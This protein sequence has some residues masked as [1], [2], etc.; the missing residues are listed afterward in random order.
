MSRHSLIAISLVPSILLATGC[1]NFGLPI[2]GGQL[3]PLVDAKAEQ[4]AEQIGGPRGFGGMMMN[5]YVG[6]AGPMIR[7]NTADD[8]ADRDGT[9]TI[10]LQ[11]D[12]EQGCTMHLAYLAGHLGLD[13]LLE[14]VE[15]PAGGETTIEIPCAEMV[16]M[17]S[18]DTPGAIGC[19]LFDD[20][21]IDNVMAV[22]AFLR[23]DYNCEDTIRFTLTHDVN[24]LDADGDIEELVLQS[25]AMRQHLLDGGPMGHGH[26]GGMGMMGSHMENR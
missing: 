13:E 18:L 2:L 25:D 3:A 17:G 19:H 16:G 20:E 22:P 15:V 23:L 21:A 1:G 4:V 24:D 7:F 9:M 10:L 14:D 12:A 11:N 6:H 5:G 8:L 26:G